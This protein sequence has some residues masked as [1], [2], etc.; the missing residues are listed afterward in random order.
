M[1]NMKM[2]LK[3]IQLGPGAVHL[4]GGGRCKLADNDLGQ[5]S[6]E[7]LLFTGSQEIQTKVGAG[8]D[9]NY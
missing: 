7:L 2:L 4:N 3:S 6:G 8:D 1:Q 9:A 5:D